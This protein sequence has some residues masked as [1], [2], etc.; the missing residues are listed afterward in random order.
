MKMNTNDQAP[1]V[2]EN[3]IDAD[4]GEAVYPREP[5]K[6]PAQVAGFRTENAPSTIRMLTPEQVNSRARNF[7]LRFK[8]AAIQE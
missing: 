4:S 2:F 5:V 8:A 1:V 7:G 3:L 6:S